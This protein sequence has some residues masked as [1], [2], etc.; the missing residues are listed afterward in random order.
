VLDSG[1]SKQKI[2]NWKTNIDLYKI[3]PI[4]K[5][6]AKKR[7]GRAGR[8]RDGKCFRLFTYLEYSRLFEYPNPEIQRLDLSSLLLHI[9]TSKFSISISIF[10]K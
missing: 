8:D 9:L 2:M 1:L 4:S 7:A 3:S 5:S 10:L 6:E